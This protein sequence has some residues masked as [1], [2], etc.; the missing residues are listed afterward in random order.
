MISRN[1]GRQYKQSGRR[2]GFKQKRREMRGREKLFSLVSATL[3]GVWNCDRRFA[4][5]MR[6]PTSLTRWRLNVYALK[7]MSGVV[8][9]ISVVAK[10]SLSSSPTWS[11]SNDDALRRRS[12]EGSR[13][14]PARERG[15]ASTKKLLDVTI[16]KP[17]IQRK[18]SWWVTSSLSQVLA[19]SLASPASARLAFVGQI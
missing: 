15:S 18:G 19:K 3:S 4:C 12:D 10:R 16:K 8:S 14:R 9:R 2:R 17:S 7:S 6:S 5:S 13:K 11:V 1:G